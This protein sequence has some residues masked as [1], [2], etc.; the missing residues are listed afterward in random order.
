MRPLTLD[1][2]A[3]LIGEAPE[4][5]SYRR[6]QGSVRILNEV[7]SSI[8]PAAGASG[9]SRLATFIEEGR[10]LT[11]PLEDPRS[12][13]G[14]GSLVSFTQEMRKE[15]SRPLTGALPHGIVTHVNRI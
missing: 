5:T 3:I 8:E 7:T 6:N 15:F 10:V 2:G 11:D 13:C 14:L 4:S 12:C 1:C 9:S